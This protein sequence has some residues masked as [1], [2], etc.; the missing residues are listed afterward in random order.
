MVL[1]DGR[2]VARP[3]VVVA[4]DGGLMGYFHADDSSQYD[5]W[6]LWDYDT[7]EAR[8]ELARAGIEIKD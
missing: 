6:L 3:E 7:P 4:K 5:S 1:S 8:A 2:E